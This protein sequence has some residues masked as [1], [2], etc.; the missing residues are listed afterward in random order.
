MKIVR[1]WLRRR[2]N[3]RDLAVVGAL[4]TGSVYALDMW[5]RMGGSSG[6]IYLAL[7][8]L[9]RAGYVLADWAEQPAGS[10]RRIYRLDERRSLAGLQRVY[11]APS[12]PS[13]TK[14]S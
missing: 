9:E 12:I 7:D 11:A 6:G 8:R 14:G 10:R 3:R 5:D 4:A 1:N 2:R 13:D